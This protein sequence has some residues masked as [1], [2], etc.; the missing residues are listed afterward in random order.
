MNQI[1]KALGD[2]IAAI[3]TC[4]EYERYLAAKKEI[5]KYP[6]LKKKAD[7]FRRLKF[8]MQGSD[9][10]IF[11]KTDQLRKEHAEVNSNPVVWEY[12]TA[13]NVFCRIL[14]QINWRLLENLDFDIGT[15]DTAD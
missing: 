15:E 9:A 10:D 14:R 6:L 8:E 11:E 3:E 2:L 7:E 5:E 4:E 12:L 1:K 13:E